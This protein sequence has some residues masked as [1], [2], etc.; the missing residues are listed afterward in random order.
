MAEGSQAWPCDFPSAQFARFTVASR[1]DRIETGARGVA[2]GGPRTIL[3]AAG[4][5]QPG[6]VQELGDIVP[7]LLEIKAKAGTPIRFHVRIEVGDEQALPA[8]EIARE[9]NTLL[10]RV[11]EDLRLN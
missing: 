7:K 1:A 11:R 5:L 3:V 8:E 6:Q 2:D 10:Q 9:I 4:E